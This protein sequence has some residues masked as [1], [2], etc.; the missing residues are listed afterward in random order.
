[1]QTGFQ[2]LKF[3]DIFKED[4][5]AVLDLTCCD[6]PP[7]IPKEWQLGLREADSRVSRVA[8]QEGFKGHLKILLIGL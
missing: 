5:Y 3:T 6:C 7:A 2:R 1:M 8:E 4:D